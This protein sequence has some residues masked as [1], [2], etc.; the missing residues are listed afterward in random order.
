MEQHHKVWEGRRVLRRLPR[1][2][3]YFRFRRSRTP[4]GSVRRTIT[5]VGEEL[6]S[7]RD[8]RRRLEYR[9]FRTEGGEIIVHRVRWSARTT[10]SDEGKVFRFPLSNV[11]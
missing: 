8:C 11:T 5:F 6:L 1:K 10:A 7:F 4:F 2:R 9:I 3:G